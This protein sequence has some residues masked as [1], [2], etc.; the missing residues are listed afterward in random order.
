[1]VASDVRADVMVAGVPAIVKKDL[2]V[3]LT[4]RARS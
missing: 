2:R 4:H 1:V 3:D